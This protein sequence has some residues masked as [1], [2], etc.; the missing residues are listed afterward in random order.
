MNNT[1]ILENAYRT[2]Y[3]SAI[4]YVEQNNLVA[5]KN[6]L[7]KALESAI[8]LIEQSFGSERARYKA[9]AESVSAMIEQINDKLR[10]AEEE[11]RRKANVQPAA[12][13]APSYEKEPSN[14]EPKR[15]KMSVDEALAALNELE[16]LQKVKEKV[17]QLIAEINISNMRKAENL[18][19]HTKT[20][21]L[22]FLGNPGTGKTTV[23]RIMADIYYALGILS[24]GQLIEVKR[25]D[26]VAE[27]V[28]QTGPKTQKVIESAMGGVLFI[29]EAYDLY[30]K[31]NDKDY[32]MEAINAL[33]KALED[34][35]DDFVVIVAG[36][37]ADMDEF[38]QSNDGLLSRFRN[39][40]VFE[41]YNGVQ[42]FNIFAA[43]CKKSDYVL[44]P[45]VEEFMHAYFEKLYRENI[46]VRSFANARTV[47]NVMDHVLERQ[48]LRL[49][50]TKTKLSRTDL[51]TI[52]LD[53][54]AD[55]PHVEI[56]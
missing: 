50:S 33:L 48:E 37:K 12:P 34:N 45:G 10:A 42:M 6:A 39:E 49:A 30:K 43:R 29:D 53:D 1:T 47:R 19:V 24:K 22:V 18:R 14:D 25:S 44:G 41:N 56:K 38:L 8:K 32:G 31:N 55:L 35:R 28:G 2:S 36:Y 16:G 40:V 11:A 51:M 54:L 21:H 46:G 20:H 23:A 7:K 3:E 9:N 5:A 52:T 27:Y 26:L 13:A 15:K 17:N 4:K